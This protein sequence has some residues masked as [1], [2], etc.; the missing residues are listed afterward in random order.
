MITNGYQNSYYWPLHY[1]MDYYWPGAGIP[2]TIWNLI[3][4]ADS[5]IA[6]ALNNNSAIAQ[7]LSGNSAIVGTISVDSM[8]ESSFM[9]YSHISTVV[10]V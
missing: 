1:W 10:N 6:S 7:T 5:M 9:Y 2:S 4:Y 3:V 8:I